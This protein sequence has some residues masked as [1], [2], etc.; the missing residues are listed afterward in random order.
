MAV[1]DGHGVLLWANPRAHQAAGGGG[2]GW[3]STLAALAGGQVGCA[4]GQV[5]RVRAAGL[6]TGEVLVT[7]EAAAGER[8]RL[9][10]EI[11][12]LEMQQLARALHDTAIQRV[13]AALLLLD[14]EGLPPMSRARDEL[15]Q[16]VAAGRRL[17]DRI[18]PPLLDELGV[19]AAVVAELEN[20]AARGPVEVSYRGPAGSSW[21]AA[22]DR[23]LLWRAVAAAVR[24]AGSDEGC[25]RIELVLEPRESSVHGEMGDDGSMDRPLESGGELTALGRAE[26]VLKA[27]GGGLWVRTSPGGTVTTFQ[28]PVAAGWRTAR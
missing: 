15:E 14:A 18:R 6:G 20:G 1:F 8:T 16:A 19:H 23:A 22:V 9:A 27:M 13:S 2:T 24:A 12:D 7:L 26:A 3:L 28:V 11:V 21:L 4:D 10:S 17:L 5:R 25:H